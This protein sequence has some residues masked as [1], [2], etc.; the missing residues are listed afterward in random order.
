MCI[1]IKAGLP[2]IGAKKMNTDENNIKSTITEVT[3]RKIVD[4]NI[5]TV[6]KV[7]QE[8]KIIIINNF[9][10]KVSGNI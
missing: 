9:I 6:S 8:N 3:N 5:V 1:T 10:R 4:T 7:T 2:T